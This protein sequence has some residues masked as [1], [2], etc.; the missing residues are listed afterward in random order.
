MQDIVVRDSARF[1]YKL[2]EVH[3]LF[4]TCGKINTCYNTNNFTAHM[5]TGKGLKRLFVV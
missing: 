3:G 2:M 5:Y 4:L 1:K